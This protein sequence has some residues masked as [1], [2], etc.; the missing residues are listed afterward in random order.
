MWARVWSAVIV[1]AVVS[2]GCSDGGGQLPPGEGDPTTAQAESGGTGSSSDGGATQNVVCAN[3]A[4]QDCVIDL[5]VVNGVHNC[6]KGVQICE[7][8]RWSSCKALEP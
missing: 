6:A 8:G 2:I 1:S 4:K 3:F 5:G 7:N